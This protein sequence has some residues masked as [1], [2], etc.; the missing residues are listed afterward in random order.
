MDRIAIID[1]IDFAEALFSAAGLAHDKAEAVAAY[2]VEA[3]ALGHTTHGLALAPWYLQSIADGVMT[4]DGAPEV[5]SD[6]GPA[7]CW[8]GRRLPGAWLTSE[9][10][11][12]AS[13]RARQYGTATLVIGDSHHIGALAAYLPIATDQGLMVSIASS[14]PSGA[15]VAPFGGTTGVFTPDPV[16]YGIPT[17][18][19]PILIDI[20]ASITTV[21]MAQRLIR[22]GRRY[23][24][25]WLMEADGTPTSDPHAVTRGGTLLPTGGRDHGQK[26]YGMALSVEAVTQGL[27]GYGRA[28]S[29]KGTNAA[30]TISVYDPAAFGGR[31]AFLKQTGWLTD[32]CRASTRLPGGAPVRLPGQAALARKREALAEGV[33]LYPGILASLLTEAKKYGVTPPK[34]IRA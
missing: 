28:D 10:V 26:G 25:N 32:A 31:D 1:L 23:D 9:G 29:P 7:I 17:P 6:K 22:E 4:K 19:E 27:A 24:A 30:V 33:K 13:A 2:L 14:S 18:D 15:Q 21:N 11:K 8:R 5:L 16:A 12:L 20:S 3:D 34:T